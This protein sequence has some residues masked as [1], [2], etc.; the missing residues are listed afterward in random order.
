MIVVVLVAVAVSWYRGQENPS[1]RGPAVVVDVPA[2]ASMGSVTHTL[3]QR[4]VIGS[5]LAFRINLLF[6]GT[7]VVQAGRY[8]LHRNEDF[9]TVRQV[10]GAGPDVFAVDVPAGYTVAEVSRAVGGVPGHGAAHFTR[11]ARSGAVASPWLA[12][13]PGRPYNLDGLL[14]TGSYL[15]LPGESDTSV[16]RQMVAR[17][18][19][20][21]RSVD[22][23]ANA[24]ALGISP[25]EAITVASIVQK[26]AFSPGDSAAATAFNAP[27]VAR[28]IYNRLERGTPL[29]DDSTVLYAEGRDGGP[30]TSSDLAVDSPYNT[31]QH[32]GLTPTPICFPSRRALVAAL[33]PADGSWQFF[34]LT[35]RDG[36]ETFSDTFAGQQAAEHLAATRGLP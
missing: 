16:L 13:V 28:V 33:H 32:T 10:L 7:P 8:L 9:G 20:L 19:A 15:V 25:Y 1:P 12:P 24:G 27:R 26:E 21:A 6:N 29:Q 2:G 11:T 36:T 22:L 18:D 34:V 30:V 31:Y 35:N 3:A 17:F 23:P 14:G 4:G 5:T